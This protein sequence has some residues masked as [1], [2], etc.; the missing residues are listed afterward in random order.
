MRMV[1]A[2]FCFTPSGIMSRMS[3]MTAARS[4]RSKC[5]SI[6]CFVTVFAMPFELRPSNC[7]ARRLP[8]QRSRSGTMPRRKKSHTRHMGAQKPHPGPFPTGPVL[9]L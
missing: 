9:N 6:R 5:D 4:S 7:R 2:L 8:S 1:F 3:C